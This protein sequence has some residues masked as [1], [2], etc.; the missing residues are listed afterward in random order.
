MDQGQIVQEIS[1]KQVLDLGRERDAPA[2]E[3]HGILHRGHGLEEIVSGRG[4]REDV[5]EG[6]FRPLGKGIGPA[7]EIAQVG[8]EETQ[9]QFLDLVP[10]LLIVR[11]DPFRDGG[12]F[13]LIEGGLLPFEAFDVAVDH[14]EELDGIQFL[15]LVFRLHMEDVTAD[16]DRLT[17][18]DRFTVSGEDVREV[19][20]NHLVIPVSNDLI[21]SVDTVRA[22]P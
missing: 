14:C 22:D 11:P 3:P 17:G 20:I 15:A 19:P 5:P 18:T 1:D 4:H 13:L 21:R 7:A 2:P 8:G 16:A 10:V 12:K 9:H 6:R